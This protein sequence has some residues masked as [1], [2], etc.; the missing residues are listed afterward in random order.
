MIKIYWL[1]L[2]DNWS[3]ICVINSVKLIKLSYRVGKVYHILP[4][5]TLFLIITSNYSDI[6][7]R[8]A[9]IYIESIL[10][11]A[12]KATVQSK[13]SSTVSHPEQWTSRPW[14]CVFGHSYCCKTNKFHFCFICLSPHMRTNFR[15]SD[16]YL[17]YSWC[18]SLFMYAITIH[19]N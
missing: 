15:N 19:F 7:F 18:S 12:H 3:L 11:L 1:T 14:N 2:N 6:S 9:F 10:C 5:S 4:S 8:A 17:P 16:F 13:N